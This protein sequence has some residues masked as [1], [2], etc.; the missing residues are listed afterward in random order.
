MKDLTPQEFYQGL[1]TRNQEVEIDFFERSCGI[2]KNAARAFNIYAPIEIDNFQEETYIRVIEKVMY[3]ETIVIEDNF[4]EG[5]THGIAVNVIR[6]FLR[7][8]KRAI[9]PEIF[10]D[11]PM[12]TNDEWIE[13]EW[14]A[15]RAKILNWA[16][17]QLKKDCQTILDLT[18]WDNL[19]SAEVAKHHENTTNIHTAVGVRNKL[20]SCRRKLREILT[21]TG[22]FNN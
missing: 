5:Y 9:L 21:P 4:P 18:Y 16:I 22:Y 8:Q 20:T 15:E 14:K 1:K 19:R 17:S 10:P 7:Q 11:V 6:E 12:P 13:N 3:D 2:V